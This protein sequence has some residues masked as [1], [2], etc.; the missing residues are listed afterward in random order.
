M[1]KLSE[2]EITEV[3]FILGHVSQALIHLTS[4]CLPHRRYSVGS[5][6]Y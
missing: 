4:L 3:R 1:L 5:S 6:S 2:A